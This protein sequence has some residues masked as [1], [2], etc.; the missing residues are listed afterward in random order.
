MIRIRF[1]SLFFAGA[2]AVV[3]AAPSAPSPTH[4][5]TD[6]AMPRGGTLT[7]AWWSEPSALMPYTTTQVPAR[8]LAHFALEGLTAVTP[9]GAYEPWLA[10]NVPT[11]ANGDVKV[12][13]N[14]GMDVTYRIQ[15]GINW[16]DG[17]SL[18]SEDVKFTWQFLMSE[19]TVG[20]R[21]G[22]DRI[23][24]IDT[25]DAQTAV[26]RYREIYAGYLT[27]F[28]FVL[29]KHLAGIPD[30][31]K[32]DYA[33]RPVGTGPFRVT[34]FV[35]GDH[36]TFERNAGYRKP[37]RPLLDRIFVR[38]VPKRDEALLQLKAGEVDVMAQLTEAQAADV[39]KTS[40]LKLLT[41]PSSQVWRAE[42]N[43]AKPGRPADPR[44]AHPVLGDIAMRHALVLATPKQQIVTSL[45][46]GNAEIANSILAIGW[47]APTDLKQES[48]DPVKAKQILDAA[49]WL[50]G[51]DGTRQ[52]G[53]VRASVTI[54][55][56]SQ[57]SV[58][59]RLEQVLVDEWKAIGVDLKIRNVVTGQLFAADGPVRQGD[60]DIDIYAELIAVDPHTRLAARY[61]SK[62]IPTPENKMSGLNW[63]RFATPEMDRLLD[64]AAVT[65]DRTERVGIYRQLLGIVNDQYLNIW[66]Y[67]Q[68]NID[69]F[70]SSVG[71]YGK[72]NPW[73][74][75]GWDAENWY[76]RR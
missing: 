74:T 44:V 22:Y 54:M 33:R 3:C 11:V 50:P 45:L 16:S 34:E 60:F 63:N 70:R 41:G 57:D 55:G 67:T 73:M 25:P 13:G 8:T 48:Y 61:S 35:A 76:V 65:F 30:V 4:G 26:M 37:D 23:A 53:G 32:S 69:A 71:G 5:A 21:D 28:E 18:S 42:F 49:G 56:P 7:I 36:I 9:D 14:G 29:P 43:L 10:S 46:G 1:A 62:G 72:S 51:S 38:F 59:E 68:Q 75:F 2:L 17:R 12:L 27:L 58:R 52:K 15:S 31:T 19:P 64:K 47:A 24:S 40:E 66:L 20:S 39:A 6:A